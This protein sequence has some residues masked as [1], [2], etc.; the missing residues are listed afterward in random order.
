VATSDLDL[1]QKNHPYVMGTVARST[2]TPGVS[3]LDAA[4]YTFDKDYGSRVKVLP[5]GSAQ[6]ADIGVG[7]DAT[8]GAGV[9][10]VRESGAPDPTMV[11]RIKGNDEALAIGW[12]IWLSMDPGAVVIRHPATLPTSLVGGDE[13]VVGLSRK[14]NVQYVLAVDGVVRTLA[15][16]PSTDQ[17]WAAGDDGLHGRVWRL[18]GMDAP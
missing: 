5:E 9:G 8:K 17:I 18:L 3:D 10:V 12:R 7:V 2:G 1:S 4:I 14:G 15:R 6:G 13:A 11:V 16:R